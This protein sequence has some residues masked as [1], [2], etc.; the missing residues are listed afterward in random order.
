MYKLN[1]IDKK[2]L[3]ILQV[4]LPLTKR[5]YADLGGRIGISE[6]EVLRITQN[7]KEQNIVRQISAIFDTRSLG[8]KSS[9]VAMAI[10]KDKLEDA[11]ER[12]NKH[13]GVSHNYRRN[14]YYNLWFT[15]AVPPDSKLGIQKT[16]DVLHQQAK[17]D[18][19]RPM[20]TLKLYKIGVNLDITGDRAPDASDKPL[21]HEG[22]INK[23]D[24]LTQTQI[25]IIRAL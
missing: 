10:P 21:Y 1:D 25:G 15:V 8:Y 6:D 3:N 5:P 13:P 18:V 11:A 22:K 23:Q 9:L 14:H 12:I 20:P 2:L 4:E 16:I 7:L 24:T 17:A 19:T